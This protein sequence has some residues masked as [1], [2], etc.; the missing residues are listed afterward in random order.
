MTILKEKT[1]ATLNLI[2]VTG[3]FNKTN[4]I[5]MRNKTL[6]C[7]EHGFFMTENQ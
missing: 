7:K 4:D 1:K 2:K 6:P 5:N 3:G